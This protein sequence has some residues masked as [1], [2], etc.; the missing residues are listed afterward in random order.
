MTNNEVMYN[1][2]LKDWV[3]GTIRGV[4]AGEDWNASWRRTYRAIGGKSDSI[5]QKGC[6]CKGTQTLYE[7][8]RIKNTRKPLRKPGLR[9]IWDNYTKNGT[10]SILALELLRENPEINL[11]DLWILIQSRIRSDLSEEP[12]GSNQGGPTIA[13]KLW[14]LGMIVD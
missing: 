11:T 13:F 9:E 1:V 8:G 14:H 4:E 6:P 7:L 5:G 3:L 12:A 2:L 10:Y